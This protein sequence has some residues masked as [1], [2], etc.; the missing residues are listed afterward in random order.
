MWWAVLR[1]ARLLPKLQTLR[2]SAG[3]KGSNVAPCVLCAGD[4]GG[5]VTTEEYQWVQDPDAQTRGYHP[6][7]PRDPEGGIPWLTVRPDP[8]GP[9]MLLI[10]VGVMA[11]VRGESASFGLVL[12][13]TALH[14]ACLSGPDIHTVFRN[15]HQQYARKV[16]LSR[17]C[18]SWLCQNA[19]KY[20]QLC[21]Q[22][23]QLNIARIHAVLL[24]RWSGTR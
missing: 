5:L 17:A 10:G 6:V 18:S 8:A 1:Q 4:T 14:H 7:L 20:N 15:C 24:R 2:V 11:C 13:L 21:S 23:R 12:S 16:N 22:Y 9:F 19:C 3:A